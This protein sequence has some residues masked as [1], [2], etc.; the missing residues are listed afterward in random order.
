MSAAPAITAAAESLLEAFAPRAAEP[1]W[2]PPI[3]FS[4]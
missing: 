4:S 3:V 1:P 2:L